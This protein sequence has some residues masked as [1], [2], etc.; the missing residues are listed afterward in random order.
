MVWM[1]GF[2]NLFYENDVRKPVTL[3]A[4]RIS[5]DIVLLCVDFG[6]IPLL[7]ISKRLQQPIW[8]SSGPQRRLS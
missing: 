6:R 1:H 4:G 7:P 8:G 5:T 2:R 3:V